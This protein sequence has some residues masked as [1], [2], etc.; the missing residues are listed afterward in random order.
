[1]VKAIYMRQPSS[2]SPLP[3]SNASTKQSR[4]EIR[5]D[6]KNLPRIPEVTGQEGSGIVHVDRNLPILAHPH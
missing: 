2:P 3:G 6:E 5:K 4:D 1:M